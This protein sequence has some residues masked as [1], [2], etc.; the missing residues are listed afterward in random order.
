MHL[1]GGSPL[2]AHLYKIYIRPSKGASGSTAISTSSSIDR[3]R[4]TVQSPSLISNKHP[5]ADNRSQH[6]L[7][8]RIP[9]TILQDTVV[10]DAQSKPL[11]CEA[12]SFV[13]TAQ[14]TPT[15]I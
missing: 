12:F 1:S 6:L 3:S 4:I 7:R 15:S 9:L 8:L 10:I 13:N 5:I 2:S 11:G 14:A